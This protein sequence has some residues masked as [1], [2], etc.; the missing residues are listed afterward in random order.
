MPENAQILG[1][2]AA[3]SKILLKL[4]DGHSVAEAS[5]ALGISIMTGRTHLR[6]MFAK[7]NCTRQSDLVRVVLQHPVW[8]LDRA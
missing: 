7:L 1:I 3:E 5:A 6:S 4:I 2:T 8:M